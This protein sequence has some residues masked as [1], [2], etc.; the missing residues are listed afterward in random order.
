MKV[1][2]SRYFQKRSAGSGK[3]GRHRHRVTSSLQVEIRDRGWEHVWLGTPGEVHQNPGGRWER[4]L[5]VRPGGRHFVYARVSEF[6][7]ALLSEDLSHGTAWAMWWYLLMG[8][9]DLMV[10]LWISLITKFP[11]SQKQLFILFPLSISAR[12]KDLSLIKAVSKYRGSWQHFMEQEAE[13][14]FFSFA[15]LKSR[16]KSVRF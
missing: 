12:V 3:S 1:V 5:A 14:H 15:G 16:L 10:I 6:G 2:K 4:G 11:A 9:H 7:G 13:A 8:I